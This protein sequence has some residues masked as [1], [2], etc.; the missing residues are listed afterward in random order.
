MGYA[1]F[2][3][4]K[5]VLSG[6]ITTVQL[7]QTQRSDEQLRLATNTSTMQAK[8]TNLQVNQSDQL[9]KLYADLTSADDSDER[10]VVQ[11]DIDAVQAE[12]DG[13][14]AEINQQIYMVSIKENAIEME[15]KRL[16][17]RLQALKKISESVEKAEGDAIDKSTP[18]FDGKA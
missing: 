10:A 18:K 12:F 7:K 6:L 13:E 9:S 2:A 11:A 4:R 15:I 16:D 3:Q 14:I 1:L 5:L 8:I 17:T